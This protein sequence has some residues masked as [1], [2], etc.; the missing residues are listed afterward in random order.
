M[1]F[2]GFTY[3]EA[4]SGTGMTFWKKPVPMPSGRPM[5]KALAIVTAIPLQLNDE[6]V[7]K[8]QLYLDG[9]SVDSKYAIEDKQM[10]V[11]Q[12]ILHV[13]PTFSLL[14]ELEDFYVRNNDYEGVL[15]EQSE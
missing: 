15:N 12:F 2:A 13:V 10:T 4:A 11:E 9:S 7:F 8:T 1:E 5:A 3:S 14:L 6:F